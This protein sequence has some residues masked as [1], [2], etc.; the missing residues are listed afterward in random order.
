[1]M[2][3]N[4]AR[5]RIEYYG[6]VDAVAPVT[7]KAFDFLYRAL[8]SNMRD[9]LSHAQEFSQW[10]AT[11]YPPGR[12]LPETADR[13]ELLETWLAERATDAHRDATSVQPRHWQFFEEVC[14]AGGRIG[15]AE[16]DRFGFG[17]QQQMTA[18]VT[19]LVGANLMVREVDPDDGTRTV[20]SVTS[21]GWLVHFHHSGFDMPPAR[22]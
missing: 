5:T 22:A 9:S 16:Y 15:S 4:A 14:E 20:N 8:H 1:M 6:D 12:D 7:P 3:V 19:A 17:F 2:Q 11:E 10:L 18:A 13:D 21:I